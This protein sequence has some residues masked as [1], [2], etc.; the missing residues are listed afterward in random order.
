MSTF[1]TAK[2]GG[3]GARGETVPSLTVGKKVYAAL[4]SELPRK[5]RINPNLGVPA[6]YLSLRFLYSPSRLSI[7]PPSMREAGCKP[8]RYTSGNCSC[9]GN[10]HRYRPLGMAA[11]D[12]K[13]PITAIRVAVKIMFFLM[14]SNSES[15]NAY[16]TLN[17]LSKN[18]YSVKNETTR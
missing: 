11:G 3:G 9:L 12:F 14:L 18:I 8:P 15:I 5:T 6:P 17:I 7:A 4:F 1:C 2:K 10:E 16:Q 13:A